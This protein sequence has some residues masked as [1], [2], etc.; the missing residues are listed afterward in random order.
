[1]VL[2]MRCESCSWRMDW[3]RGNRRFRLVD[4]AFVVGKVVVRQ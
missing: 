2:L 1:M 4:E 3:E